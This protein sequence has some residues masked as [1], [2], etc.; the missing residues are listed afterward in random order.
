MN[1]VYHSS[2]LAQNSADGI[3]TVSLQI[4]QYTEEAA[5][6][7]HQPFLLKSKLGSKVLSEWHITL[8]P[9]TPKKGVK[10]C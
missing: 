9:L 7:L 10:R 6:F 5:T 4:R 2:R 1:I 8:T 3:V